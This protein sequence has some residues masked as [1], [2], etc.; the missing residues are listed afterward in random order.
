VTELVG[1]RDVA[2]EIG[3][4]GGRLIA[5]SVDRPE[6]SARVVS[7]HHLPFHIV[8]DVDRKVIAQYGLVHHGGGPKK[9]DVAIPAHMLIDRGGRIAWRHIAKRILDRPYPSTIL[10]EI[11]KLH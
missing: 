3:R 10:N 9:E 4:H 6:D 8:S 2:E 1:L 7:Q 5:V 11:Q